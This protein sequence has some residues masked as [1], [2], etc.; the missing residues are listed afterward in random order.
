[1]EEAQLV[2]IQYPFLS[3]HDRPAAVANDDTSN[4]R[5]Q[6]LG[7]SGSVFLGEIGTVCNLSFSPAELSRKG[8][9]E[10]LPALAAVLLGEKGDDVQS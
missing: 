6:R 5:Y 9:A 3:H 8:D 2:P 4:R 1:M 10:R 7:Q